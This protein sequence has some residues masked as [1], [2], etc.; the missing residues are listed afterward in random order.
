MKFKDPA[1]EEQIRVRDV[2]WTALQDLLDQPKT[3]A[4]IDLMLQKSREALE[5]QYFV[6]Y[7][8]LPSPTG[9]ML[10]LGK[11]DQDGSYTIDSILI[12]NAF[13]EEK[14]A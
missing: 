11:R 10:I 9:L 8:D 6:A 3:A 14:H 1:T 13:Q 7:H 4:L 2:V 12:D 5:G